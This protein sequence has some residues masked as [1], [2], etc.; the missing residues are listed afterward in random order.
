MSKAA[1]LALGAALGLSIPGLALADCQRPTAPAAVDGAKATMDQM[2][3]AKKGVSAFMADSDTYQSCVLE[4]VAKQKTAATAA[5]TKLDPAIAKAAD[6]QVSANQAD[7]EHVG[8]DFN[9]AAK[10]YKAAH[11]S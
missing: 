5:K 10:A 11:P 4:D 1:I 6:K 3:E 2:M 7:K 8:A 9:A